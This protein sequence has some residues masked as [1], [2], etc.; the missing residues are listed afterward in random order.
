LP[1]GNVGA[2]S[3]AHDDRVMAM[4]MGLAVRAEGKRS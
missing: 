2:R 1:N 3:G 4:A